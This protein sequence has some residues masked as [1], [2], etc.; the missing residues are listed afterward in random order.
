[1]FS[2]IPTETLVWNDFHRM[3]Q[4]QK[5]KHPR[6]SIIASPNEAVCLSTLNVMPYAEKSTTGKGRLEGPPMLPIVVLNVAATR[7][8]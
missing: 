3:M 5:N 2:F 1:V 6:Q 8:D 7:C 4:I